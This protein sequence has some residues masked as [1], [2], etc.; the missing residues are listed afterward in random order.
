[1]AAGR[2]ELGSVDIVEGLALV[3]GLRIEVLNVVSLLRGWPGSWPQPLVTAKAAVESL[4]GHWRE[5][6]RPTDAQFDN[7]TIFQGAHQHRD[8]ISRVMRTCRRLDVIPVFVPPRESDFQVAIENF[9]GRWQAKVWACF[10]HDSLA[11]LQERSRRY[12]SAYRQAA[13]VGVE[14]APQRPPFPA[15]WQPDLHARPEGVVIFLRRT[16]QTGTVRLLGRPFEADPP[17][18]HRLVRFELD[19][20]TDAVRFHALRRRRAPTHQPLLREVPYV[21]PRAGLHE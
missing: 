14:A 15:L 18:S 5:F 12:V 1:M 6:G 13:A 7:D 10:Y 9:N 20:H 21:F 3:G 11:D 17:C 16:S 8:S 19:L 4:V 2:A